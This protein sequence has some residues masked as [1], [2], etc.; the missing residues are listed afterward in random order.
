MVFDNKRV[1]SI[2]LATALLGGTVGAFV[3]RSGKTAETAQVQT[4]GAV[5]PATAQ[6]T[7]PQ[8][9]T[10]QV[11]ENTTPEAYREG[12]ADG[13]R[14]ALD[15]DKS[16]TNTATERQSAPRVVYRNARRGSSASTARYDNSRR[17]YY[18]YEQQPRKRSFWS[19]HRD[20]LTVAAGAGGGAI[21]GGLIGGK[22]GAAIGALAGGG[23]SALYTYKLRKRS[24][25]Y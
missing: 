14:M 5:S 17:V 3:S 25:N 23:G 22:K 9:T 13:V 16:E 10:D 20:K 8:T 1:I 11:A 21:I 24:R 19:K 15:G 2:A 18:D 12:F 4:A 6:T 7:A